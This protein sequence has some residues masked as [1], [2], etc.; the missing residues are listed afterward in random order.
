[1]KT[2]GDNK[3]DDV[4]EFIL[5]WP[6]VKEVINLGVAVVVALVFVAFAIWLLIWSAKK[7]HP[8]LVVQNQ[9]IA[10]N[11]NA[12]EA[13]SQSVTILGDILKEVTL[14]FAVHDEKTAEIKQDIDSLQK[15]ISILKVSSVTKDELGR[16]HGRI[17]DVSRD[18]AV[19]GKDIAVIREKV[20]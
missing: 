10:N 11:T 7:V 14:R 6:I 1:M 17:D 4:A 3:G 8:I 16:I 12:T 9:L 20:N 13:V 18:I 19:M 15:D 2:T 5:N